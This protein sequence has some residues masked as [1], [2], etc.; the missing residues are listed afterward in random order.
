MHLK[1]DDR[2]VTLVEVLVTIVIL[3]IIAGPLAGGLYVFFRNSDETTRRLSDSHDAQML[4]NYFAQDVQALGV[5]DWTAAGFPFVKSVE[6]DIAWNAGTLRCGGS[7][8]AKAMIRMA[9]DTPVADGAPTATSVVAYVLKNVGAE[10]QLHRLVCTTDPLNPISD[11]VVVHN[12]AGIPDEPDCTPSPC[13]SAPGIPR[14]IEWDVQI[15]SPGSTSGALTVRVSG[16]R[17]QT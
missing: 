13:S 17:R 10:K 2:G 7:D 15:M 3:G 16:Q 11:V 14:Y 12:L 4:A 9:R 1:R 6:T 8:V 5:R